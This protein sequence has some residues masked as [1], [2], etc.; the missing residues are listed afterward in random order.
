M[1]GYGWMATDEKENGLWTWR[2]CF[3]LGEGEQ[4]HAG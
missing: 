4:L 3:K 2:L 1:D